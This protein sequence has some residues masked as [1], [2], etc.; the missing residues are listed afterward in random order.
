MFS[1]GD[2]QQKLSVRPE[3][4]K[5][6]AAI[7][8]SFDGAQRLLGFASLRPTLPELASW[9]LLAENPG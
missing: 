8:S 7:E 3:P 5:D 1:D 6:E 4:H 2:R 9:L